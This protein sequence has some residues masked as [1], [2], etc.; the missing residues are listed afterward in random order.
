METVWKQANLTVVVEIKYTS[1]NNIDKL[2]KEAMTQICKR[3]Y[4]E[5]V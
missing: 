3:K 4:Y 2:L 5:A 1:N